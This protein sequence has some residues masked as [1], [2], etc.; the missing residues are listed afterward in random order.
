MRAQRKTFHQFQVQQ[1]FPA[2]KPVNSDESKAL[3]FPSKGIVPIRF[4]FMKRFRYFFNL[5]EGR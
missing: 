5:R 3:V 4:R 2:R 1:V